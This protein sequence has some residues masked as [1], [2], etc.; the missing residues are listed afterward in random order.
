[1]SLSTRTPAQIVGRFEP[2]GTAALLRF[3]EFRSD[4]LVETG[5]VDST[6]SRRQYG[7]PWTGGSGAVLSVSPD[8]ILLP[9]AFSE[10]PQFTGVRQVRSEL[11]PGH[12]P[13]KPRVPQ[14][15]DGRPPLQIR[16]AAWRERWIPLVVHDKCMTR[17][18]VE[19]AI[20]AHAS[21]QDVAHQLIRRA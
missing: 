3:E 20:I 7:H 15:P 9:Q 5:Q 13:Q 6:R 21:R 11:L 4:A 18:D 1:M 14:S 17:V 16:G 8:P 2:R 12:P 10:P 19:H